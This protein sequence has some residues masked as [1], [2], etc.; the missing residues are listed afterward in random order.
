MA[1]LMEGVQKLTENLLQVERT[2]ARREVNNPF[3]NFASK[4][5][6]KQMNLD[7]ETNNTLTQ[8]IIIDKINQ[9]FKTLTVTRVEVHY[10]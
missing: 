9:T 3:L 10:I 6:E 2:R 7:V 5:V 1:T 4:I 8:P